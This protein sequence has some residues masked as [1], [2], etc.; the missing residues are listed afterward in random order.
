MPGSLSYK[1]F[2]SLMLWQIMFLF[3]CFWLCLYLRVRLKLAREEHHSKG[4][5]NYYHQM[6]DQE[7]TLKEILPELQKSKFLQLCHQNASISWNCTESLVC[8]YLDTLKP[9]SLP[10]EVVDLLVCQG[11]NSFN[12]SVQGS[13]LG[14]YRISTI[15]C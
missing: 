8:A 11:S 14:H 9:G 15:W 4:K 2:L 1:I 10:K 13:T 12:A 7:L 6:L 3:K 5:L